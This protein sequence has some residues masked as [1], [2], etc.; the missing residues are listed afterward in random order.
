MG[1]LGL[2]TGHDGVC[3]KSSSS[4][5]SDHESQSVQA[6]EE[7]VTAETGW[8]VQGEAAGTGDGDEAAAG[9]QYLAVFPGSLW[10]QL[11]ESS[12][13]KAH[14]SH[15]CRTH[16]GKGEQTLG[17]SRGCCVC[18]MSCRVFTDA[19]QCPGKFIRSTRSDH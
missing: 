4:S 18:Q 11:P 12:A 10:F 15:F 17:R 14:V 5:M 3:S 6:L 19:G 8:T 7:L 16:A 1:G 9:W 2:R 13:C